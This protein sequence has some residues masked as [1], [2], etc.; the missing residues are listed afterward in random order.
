MIKPT[1]KI[2]KCPFFDTWAEN[3]HKDELMLDPETAQL[4][5]ECISQEREK[6]KGYKTIEPKKNKGGRP[7]NCRKCQKPKTQ[8]NCGRPLKITISVLH[9]LEESFMHQFSDKNACIYAGISERTLYKYQERNPEFKQRKEALKTT[10][11]MHAQHELVTSIK[12]NLNQSR[13]WAKNSS[14]MRAQFGDVSKVEHSGHI[15]HPE[16]TSDDEKADEIVKKMNDDLR[17]HYT[18]PKQVNLPKQEN[19][20]PKEKEDEGKA[21]VEEKSGHKSA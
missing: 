11:D 16:V 17:A 7:P 14:T 21:E 2:E 6:T 18:K 1:H 3:N 13:W 5:E 15:A 19:N 20:A 9:K 8:C 4:C 12:G 10:P